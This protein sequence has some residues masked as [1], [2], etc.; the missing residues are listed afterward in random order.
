MAD[1]FLRRL[2]KASMI[3]AETFRQEMLTSSD[4]TDSLFS[5]WEGRKLRYAL[6]WAFYENNAYDK[7]HRWSKTLKASYALYRYT[8]HIYNPAY[9]LGNFWSVH[10]MGGH[11]DPSAGDG[12]MSPSAIPIIVPPENNQEARLREALAQLWEWS[13]WGEKKDL[14]T[15]QGAVLGDSFIQVTDDV[16]RERVYLEVVHPSLISEMT[17]DAFGNVKSYEIAYSIENPEIEGR[18]AEYK[19]KCFR[20]AGEEVI[21]QTFLDDSPY[22]YDGKGEEWTEEY[23]F[24]PLVFIPHIDTGGKWGWAEVHANMSRIRECDD[25]ASKLSDHIRKSVD[26]PW[27]FNFPKPKRTSKQQFDP[28]EESTTRPQ[29]GRE[30]APVIYSST[31][32]AKGQ[33]LIQDLNYSGVMQHLS[34]IVGELEREYPELRY[35]NIRLEGAVSGQTLRIA[36]QPAETK[37][38]Q[39]R[40]VYDAA[41]VRAQNMALAIGGFRNYSNF[42][43]FN[44]ES[45]DRGDLKHHIG[46]RAVFTLNEVDELEGEQ[47]FW[48]TAQMAGEAGISLPSFLR[49]HGWTEKRIQLA[50]GDTEEGEIEEVEEVEDEET[51][52]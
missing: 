23:G 25:L 49:M 4:E 40:N 29:A 27:L 34:G 1:S 36:R 19:E 26:P 8:R 24:I 52:S 16:E 32:S 13:N 45:Y 6:L 50:L 35:D 33:A 15:L 14:W 48:E 37:V 7:V 22:D 17:K 9:R 10:L 39:K 46:Q 44:L 20:G 47:V 11:L 2:G 12:S 42:E 18:E 31:E 41:L 21:F 28:P 5:S 30:E 51:V 3:S 43:G 38:L